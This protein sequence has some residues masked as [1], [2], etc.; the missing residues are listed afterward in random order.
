MTI[1]TP[2]PP[3]QLVRFA[4]IRCPWCR[5]R[6]H[7]RRVSGGVKGSPIRYYR[8]R[9]CQDDGDPAFKVYIV[10]SESVFLPDR[11]NEGLAT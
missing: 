10:E 5:S 2:Q 4:R 7:V 9:S 1:P 8:C 6:E 11:Q 3:A